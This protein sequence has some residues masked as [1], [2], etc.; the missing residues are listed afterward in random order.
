[1]YDDAQ[2]PDLKVSFTYKAVSNYCVKNEFYGA[3]LALNGTW[4]E[5]NGARD[6]G[7]SD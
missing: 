6:A 4:F 7:C 3:T 1:M 5:I 2:E